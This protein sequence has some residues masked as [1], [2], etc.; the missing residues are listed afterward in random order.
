MPQNIYCTPLDPGISSLVFGINLG[1]CF[2]VLAPGIEPD[3]PNILGTDVSLEFQFIGS[4][5]TLSLT[6]GQT[7][8]LDG[9]TILFSQFSRIV[10]TGPG[11]IPAVNI[12]PT[13]GPVFDGG[14]YDA[15]P[16]A[17]AESGEYDTNNICD[18]FD[19][20]EYL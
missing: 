16:I 8:V 12:T 2:E 14:S 11:N 4:I 17:R 10:I 20:L 1:P 19:E 6:I 15:V 7:G 9:F 18:T 13:Y 3:F 5:N